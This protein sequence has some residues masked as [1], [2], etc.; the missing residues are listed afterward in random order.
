MHI[1][2]LHT[3]SEFTFLGS[4]LT[5]ERIVGLSAYNGYNA[6]AISDLLS[7]FGYFRLSKYCEMENLKP[8]YGIELF[9][10]T[11]EKHIF[12]VLLFAKNNRGLKNIFQLNSISHKNFS[13]TKRYALDFPLLGEYNDGL[14]ILIEKEIIHY[15][16]N[17]ETLRKIIDRYRSIFKDDFYVEVNFTGV[18]K[19]PLIKEIISII[20]NFELKAIPTCE[21]RYEKDDKSAFDFLNAFR[22]KSHAKNEKGFKLD[23]EYEYPFRSVSEFQVIFK[24]HPDY[25]S[26]LD[27]LISSVNATIDLKTPKLFKIAKE[28]SLREICQEKL[29]AFMAEKN[30]K[31]EKIYRERLE[32]ELSLIEEKGLEDFFLFAQEIANFLK[33]RNIPSGPGR[34]SSASSLILFLLDVNKIDPIKYNLLFERFL[35]P[36]RTEI[37]DIDIDVCWKKRQILFKY[38]FEKYKG[39]VAHIA[40]TKRL[41]P[42]SLINEISKFYKLKKEKVKLIK[43]FFYKRNSSIYTTLKNETKLMKAYSE[44][45]EIREFLDILIKIEALSQHSSVHSGGIIITPDEITNYASL[46]IADNGNPVAQIT[47]EDIESTGFIKLDILGLRFIT[48]INETIKRTKVTK[49]PLTDKKTFE[50]L[51]SGDTIGV[52]QLESTGMR[53][54]LKKVKPHSLEELSNVL[55]LYRPGPLRS[56][57]TEEYCK[58]KQNENEKGFR[59]NIKKI[60]AETKGIFIYQEQI[61]SL[62]HNIAGF[63]WELTDRFRK[64]L[65]EKEIDKIISLKNDFISGC[66]KNKIPPDEANHLFGIIVDFGSYSFN[67]A[68]SISYAYN[69]YLSAY[70]KANYP[71]DF[72]ISLLNNYIGFHSKLDRY[73]FEIR[74]KGY[75]IKE[76]NI[77]KCEIFFKKEEENSIRPGLILVKFVGYN[78]ARNIVFERK[79]NG[80]YNDIIDFCKRVKKYGLSSRSLEF[81]ILSGC[82]DF[83]GIS[84]MS[85]IKVG[86][87]ILKDISDIISEISKGINELF[88]IEEE[89]D[90]SNLLARYPSVN[91]SEDDKM[92]MSYKATDLHLFAHPIERVKDKLKNL[93]LDSLESLEFKRYFIVLALVEKIRI[94]EH[95]TSKKIAVLSL[96]DETSSVN[97]FMDSTALSLYYEILKTGN[98]YLFKGRNINGRL[99]LDEVFEVYK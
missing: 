10:K 63:S 58:R 15:R 12:P 83:M 52:F 88:P 89:L 87:E 67:K 8:I 36:A 20:E 68:H 73:L 21:T 86:A 59:G 11:L 7:T 23:L 91:E 6:V 49:V 9:I 43:K 96:V 26:N 95:P 45:R 75:K 51:S 77:N 93:Q 19:V 81:L 82:F 41:L 4:T 47:K 60:L 50:L 61:L 84:R 1:T 69:A 34:G 85:L 74:E 90:I 22:E 16:D 94:Y 46:E 13:E 79:E 48:I 42:N 14:I 65:S 30:I 3:H 66:T 80:L 98:I 5:V 64:A 28:K 33:K 18:K 54:L 2:N 44:N 40:T 62:V 70:L 32:K 37:P 92:K 53:E 27:E 38:L 57:M 55:A 24:N 76:F 78:L 39:R 72:F 17:F 71:L 56:G 35:N 25:L 31:N 97:T 29:E 99:Q